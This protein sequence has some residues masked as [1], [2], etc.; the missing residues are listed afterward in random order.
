VE[1]YS[2]VEVQG[3]SILVRKSSVI[4]ILVICEDRDNLVV[5]V[6]GKVHRRLLLPPH[7]H[8]CFASRHLEILLVGSMMLTEEVG[9][10]R[11]MESREIMD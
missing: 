8:Q 11:W 5:E 3:F 9:L 7:H 10:K 6:K 1:E 2:R 4:K